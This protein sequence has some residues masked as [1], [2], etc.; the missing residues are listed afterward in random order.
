MSVDA[1]LLDANILIYAMDSSAPQH[2]QSR[3]LLEASRERA[4]TLYLTSQVLC[5]FYSI[6]TNPRRVGV[7]RSPS[8]ALQAI[9]AVLDLPGIEVLPTP[10]RTIARWMALLERHPVIGADVFDLLL[11][12]T[13]Q[14]NNVQRI[15]TYNTGDF[16]VFPE[17]TVL[18]PPVAA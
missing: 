13:M 1:G 4:N 7:P 6:V 16:D 9:S 14:A 2:A 3:A 5:E 18:A 10:A 12:A 15:Y 17:L 11:V 8:D